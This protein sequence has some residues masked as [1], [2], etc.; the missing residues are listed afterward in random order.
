MD[1]EDTIA[2]L[3]TTAERLLEGK[4]TAET[5]DYED[6]SFC[7][8]YFVSFKRGSIVLTTNCRDHVPSGISQRSCEV[9]RNS[10]HFRSRWFGTGYN[11]LHSPVLL[12]GGVSV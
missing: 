12:S 1:L 4:F 9:L 5:H 7:G 2:K 10:K 6:H 3:P 8:T 11:L